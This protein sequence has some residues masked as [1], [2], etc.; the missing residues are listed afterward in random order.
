MIV[1]VAVFVIGIVVVICMFIVIVAIVFVMI[2]VIV[3]SGRMAA[4]QVCSPLRVRRLPPQPA[5]G[6]VARTN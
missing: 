3:T 6:H 1:N 5:V 2:V 4:G